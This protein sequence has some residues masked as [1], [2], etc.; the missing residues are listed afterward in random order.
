MA[1][2]RTVTDRPSGGGL[3]CPSSRGALADSVLIGVV[4]AQADGPR[5]VPTERALPVTPEILALA[6]P[7]SPSEVFRFASPCQ[8]GKCPHFQNQ[9]CQLAV[10]SVKLLEPVEDGLPKC[11]IRPHCRWF[12]QEGAAICKRCPQVVT[13]QFSPSETMVQIVYGILPAMARTEVPPK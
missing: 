9:A 11:S 1:E 12:R 8:A 2:D 6:E 4:T 13:D 5:V 10:R 7:V 3:L